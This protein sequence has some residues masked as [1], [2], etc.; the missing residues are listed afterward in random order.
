MTN[1][2]EK[3]AINSTNFCFFWTGEINNLLNYQFKFMDYE[4]V[5]EWVVYL[6]TLK[7][8]SRLPAKQQTE[9]WMTNI[10]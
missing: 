10:F 8:L 4:T 6:K 9:D 7:I 2:K 5:I 3:A 1:E